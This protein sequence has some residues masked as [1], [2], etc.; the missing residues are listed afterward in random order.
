MIR[1][2]IAC[3][4]R[5]AVALLALAFPMQVVQADSGG[6]LIYEDFDYGSGSVGGANGGLG[7]SGPWSTYNAAPAVVSPGLSWGSLAVAGNSVIGSATGGSAARDIGA[8]SVLDEG[9]LMANGDTLWFSVVM[10]NA[11]SSIVNVDFSFCLGTDAFVNFV[12]GAGGTF[13]QRRNLA[14][15]EGIGVSFLNANSTSGRI[16]GAYWQDDA[17]AD[18]YANRVLLDTP[19]YIN[20]DARILI[21]GRIDWGADDLTDETLTLYAP[22][23]DLNP[24]SPILAAATIPA[25]DQSAFD[26]VAFQLKG[27][28]FVDEFRFGATYEDAVGLQT[29]SQPKTALIDFGSASGLLTSSGGLTYNAPAFNDTTDTTGSVGL[30]N[31][32]TGSA[33]GWTIDVTRTS[34]GTSDAGNAVSGANPVNVFPGELADFAIA[35]LQDS[36][37]FNAG[38]QAAGELTVTI[39]GLDNSM[40]YDLLFYGSRANPGGTQTWHLTTGSGTAA[41]VMHGSANNMTTV[42]DWNGIAPDAGTIAFTASV[43]GG[44]G[45]LNFGQV[46]E[47]VPEPDPLPVIDTFIVDDRYVA[48]GSTVT[49][50]W[51][52]SGADSVILSSEAGPVAASGTLAKTIAATTTFTLSATNEVGTVEESLTVHAGPPRPNIVLFLVDDM[53]PM[54]TSVPFSCDSNGTP[55]HRNFN[56]L[57]VTPAM[58][59]LAGNG[60]RF[61]H[62]YAQPTCSPT[63]VSLMTGLNTTGHAVTSWVSTNGERLGQYAPSNYRNRGIENPDEETLPKWLSAAGYRTIHTGKGHFTDQHDPNVYDEV[64]DPRFIGFD[65]NIGGSWQGQPGSY[66]GTDNYAGPSRPSWLIPGVEEFHGTNTFLTEALTIKANEA[67]TETV[68]RGQPFF[69]YMSHYAVHAPF[70]TDPRAT[71]DYSAITSTSRSF[72]TMIE[73][74]D[75]SLGEIVAHLDAEGVAEETLIIFLGDNGSDN[76]L[77]N[78]NALPDAPYNDYPLLGMK[79]N[80]AEGGSRIPLIVAWAK[81]DPTNPFQQALPIPGNS[82]EHD[83]VACWDL[84]VTIMNVAGV[85][86]PST[87]DI[88]GQ[89]LSPY[90]S[91]TPGSHREQ[92]ILIYYPHGRD[93]NDHFANYRKGDWKLTYLWEEERFALFDLAADP[94]ES[95]DL[96]ATHPE[97]VLEMARGMARRFEEEWTT[98][99]GTIWP[100]YPSAGQGALSTAAI[101]GNLDLDGDGRNDADEDANAN[102]LLDPGETDPDDR[103]TDGDGSDDHTELRLGL[104]PLNPTKFFRAMIGP[105]P[106]NGFELRWPSQP[107][108]TF[109][110]RHSAD[111]ATPPLGWTT[112]TGVPAAASGDESTWTYAGPDTRRFF[113]IELE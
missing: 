83:I 95:S 52:V 89:D 67:I 71:G 34:G 85:E 61:T 1:H 25:L 88:H 46:V 23:T 53:G 63:R 55:V 40:L 42:V 45:A 22:D 26:T 68:G 60:M 91:G 80:R 38:D 74:M 58:E 102:G 37:F 4:G 16:Q 99:F 112:V 75:L 94:T 12:T 2:L 9:N 20:E 21:V 108:L 48:P 79:G 84:P 110:I 90:L 3:L 32:I 73:G 77:L 5:S 78:D 39:G 30:N 15:G 49:L 57:Y 65:V 59:A 101:M 6:A 113:V 87:A 93:D 36:L 24:G 14:G 28:A 56:H 10:R 103:D 11:P 66:L 62:A 70:Q 13:G 81:P 51:A 54:D 98:T 29:S 19:A 41:D 69:L 92:E 76:P 64:E 104:D 35:A 7:F 50:D 31:D 72:A 105:A 47:R 111:L 107:G 86:I 106:S 18:T 17:D 109:T 82:V 8:P 43:T 44:V 33:T 96:A 27:G 100:T 97:K